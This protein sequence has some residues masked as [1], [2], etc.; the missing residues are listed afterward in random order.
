MADRVLNLKPSTD[1]VSF[2]ENEFKRLK[3]TVFNG[4]YRKQ[5]SEIDAAN[6]TLQTH[7]DQSLKLEP[8]RNSRRLQRNTT[9]FKLIRKHA[10]S[11]YA[12]VFQNSSWKCRRGRCSAQHIVSLRLEPRPW[13]YRERTVSSQESLSCIKL[14]VLLSTQKSPLEVRDLIEAL[15]LESEAVNLPH[16]Q[17]PSHSFSDE[18][19]YVILD[20][21]LNSVT[22][23]TKQSI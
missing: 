23:H 22:V 12:A 6:K 8:N 4:M 20:F 1:I 9:A 21:F 19:A 13:D 2:F 5:L 16:S 3:L 10:E 18:P 11:F 15:Q 14:R 7:I 17:T